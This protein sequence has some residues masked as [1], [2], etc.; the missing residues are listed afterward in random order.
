MELQTQY[1]KEGGCLNRRILE[2]EVTLLDTANEIEDVGEK[3]GNLSYKR[4]WKN[5]G[6]WLCREK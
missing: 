4:K 3:W 6:T 5:R 1:K 2:N